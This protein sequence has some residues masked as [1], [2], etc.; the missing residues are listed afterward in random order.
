MRERLLF[1]VQCHLPRPFSRWAARISFWPLRRALR[2]L[3]EAGNTELSRKAQTVA[4]PE[5]KAPR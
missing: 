5:P 1:W 3:A 2:R 4:E